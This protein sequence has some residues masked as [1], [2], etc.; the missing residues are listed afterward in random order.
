L[1]QAGLANGPGDGI[2]ILGTGELTKKLTVKATAFSG[3][4]RAAIEK[5]G[6]TCELVVKTQPAP[7]QAKA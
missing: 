2:K 1:R 6:G 7:A 4:A 5:L 3:A